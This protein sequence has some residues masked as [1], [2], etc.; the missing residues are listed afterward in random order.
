MP[1]RPL[2]RRC[3]NFSQERFGLPV[4]VSQQSLQTLGETTPPCFAPQ[5]LQVR[6]VCDAM[7][8]LSGVSWQ[9][10]CYSLGRGRINDNS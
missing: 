2:S 3:S 4:S 5:I 9:L 6:T 1:N 10:R 7:R 8:N